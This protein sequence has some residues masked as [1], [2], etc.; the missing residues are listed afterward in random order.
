MLK[1]TEKNCKNCDRKIFKKSNC[2]KKNWK[3]RVKFCSPDCLDSFRRGKPSPSPLTT[4]K[5]GNKT[6]VKNRLRGKENNLWN[7]GQITLTCQGCNKT[8]Q[9]DQYRS[10]AKTC[11]MECNKSY[12][13]TKDFRMKLSEVQRAKIPQEISSTKFVRSMIRTCSRYAIWREQILAKN[14][15]TCQGCGVRGGTLHV[16]HIDP[17]LAVCLRNKIDSYEKALACEELWDVNNGRTLCL[18]CHYNTPTFGSKVYNKL[19]SK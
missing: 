9:V 4:F 6:V 1:P 12:R 2:S 3:V 8:F 11:S 7:G 18:A 15:F 17:F 14:D 16:D 10:K 5:K 19:L 13:R